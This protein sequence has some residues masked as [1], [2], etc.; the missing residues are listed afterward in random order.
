MTP[1]R[2]KRVPHTE[3]IAYD[4]PDDTRRNAVSAAIL[5]RGIRLQYSVFVVTGGPVLLSQL[6]SE[7]SRLVH[8]A[9]DS[10]LII[11]LGPEN[12]AS[13]RITELAR[14]KGRW[15]EPSAWIPW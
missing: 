1:G 4:I 11:S 12:V 14:G 9:L 5:R 3:I 7:L 8:P 15:K 2:P 13:S 6:H 10:V